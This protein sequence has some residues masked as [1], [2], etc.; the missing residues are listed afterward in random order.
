VWDWECVA[1][2]LTL[3][4]DLMRWRRGRKR[5]ASE[6]KLFLEG[7]LHKI[8][9]WVPA[10]CSSV[11]FVGVSLWCFVGIFEKDGCFNVVFLWCG[12][13]VLRGERGD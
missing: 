2:G 6:A 3:H 4:F 9:T 10:D 11:F 13:G 5:I 7:P 1:H 12:C 8:K